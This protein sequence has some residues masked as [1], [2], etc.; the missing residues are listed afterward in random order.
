MQQKTQSWKT[1][2]TVTFLHVITTTQK[3]PKR[4]ASRNTLVPNANTTISI[5]HCKN[6]CSQTTKNSMSF[7][8][9]YQMQFIPI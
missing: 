8:T 1:S 6:R 2:F 5:K 7:L 3:T 4:S 9:G